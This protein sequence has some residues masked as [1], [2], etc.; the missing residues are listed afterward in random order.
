MFWVGVRPQED[1]DTFG[2]T[3]TFKFYMNMQGG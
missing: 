3:D 1:A 2:R